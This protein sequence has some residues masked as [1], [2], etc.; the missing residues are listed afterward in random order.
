M[1]FDRFDPDAFL[2]A[3]TRSDSVQLPSTFGSVS[4]PGDHQGAG[5]FDRF[6]PDDFLGPRKN[7]KSGA[8]SHAQ[9]AQVAQVL[10]GDG[11]ACATS[12]AFA[13][14]QPWKSK[15]QSSATRSFP[16]SLET[17]LARFPGSEIVSVH[18]HGLPGYSQFEPLDMT[19]HHR[20]TCVQC[21]DPD[22]MALRWLDRRRSAVVWLHPECRRHYLAWKPT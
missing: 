15:I 9:A 18:R 10:G 7:E 17:I 14:A 22:G 13:C 6:D 1:S 11:S 19:G 21:R 5:A 4:R 16:A 2:A 8:C 20:G 3:D 12:A